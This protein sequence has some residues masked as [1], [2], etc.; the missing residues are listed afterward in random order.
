[1][2]LSAILPD[3][4]RFIQWYT[5]TIGNIADFSCRLYGG[6]DSLNRLLPQMT[7]CRYNRSRAMIGNALPVF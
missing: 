3:T 7:G 2:G 1:M 5:A 4:I 6:E